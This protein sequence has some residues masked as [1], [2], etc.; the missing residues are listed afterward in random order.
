MIATVAVIVVFALLGTSLIGSVFHIHKSAAAEAACP[1]CQIS[2]CVPVPV[3]PVG[4]LP[5][6][7]RQS[8]EVPLT[9][10]VTVRFSPFFSLHL[11][12]APPSA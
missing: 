8:G 1:I 3:T 2:H 10:G 12:R 6:P 9:L 11:S 4:L 7:L 5:F